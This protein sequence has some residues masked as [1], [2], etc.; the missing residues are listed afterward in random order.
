MTDAD[1][2]GAEELAGLEGDDRLR[3]LFAQDQPTAR[4][5]MFSAAVM[6][7]VVRR[8]FLVDVALLSGS[9]LLGGLVLW[10][11]WPTLTPVVT[12]LSHGLAPVAACLTLAAIVVTLA[13]GRPAQI[14]GFERPLG[15][16]HD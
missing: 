1:E 10:A 5:P 13:G 11:L 3:A 7:Q 6:E 15:F 4:D 9:T 8:R 12:S 2:F 14:L 16:E